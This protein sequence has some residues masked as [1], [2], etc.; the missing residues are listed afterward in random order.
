MET[1]VWTVYI[2]K[3]SDETYYVGCTKDLDKRFKKHSKGAVIFN[4]KAFA[5]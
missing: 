4:K 2:L 3:C 1:K 5:S